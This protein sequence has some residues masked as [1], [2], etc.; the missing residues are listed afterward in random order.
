MEDGWHLI[1]YRHDMAI[2][3]KWPARE[4]RLSFDGS[5]QQPRQGAMNSRRLYDPILYDRI[6]AADWQQ[7]L[8]EHVHGIARSG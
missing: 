8:S 1:S 7:N 3:V 6:A 5:H 4:H 2:R